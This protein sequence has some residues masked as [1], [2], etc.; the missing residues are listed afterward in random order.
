MIFPKYKTKLINLQFLTFIN[1]AIIRSLSS[2]TNRPWNLQKISFFL[3]IQHIV[4]IEIS[5]YV[6]VIT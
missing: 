6:V 1:L 3:F 2:S 5:I 4:I